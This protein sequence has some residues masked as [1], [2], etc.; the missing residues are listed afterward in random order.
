MFQNHPGLWGEWSF[1]H[2]WDVALTL[3]LEESVCS[4]TWEKGDTG[5]RDA[6]VLDGGICGWWEHFPGV[7]L[8]RIARVYFSPV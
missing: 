8:N 3:G 5:A 7:T 1:T 4:E 6:L 2:G